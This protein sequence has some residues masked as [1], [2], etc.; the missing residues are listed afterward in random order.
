MQRGIVG[1]TGLKPFMNLV[2]SDG[3]C[4]SVDVYYHMN[5]EEENW[6]SKEADKFG[7]V[8]IIMHCESQ[9]KEKG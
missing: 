2:N 5:V 4:M 6:G 8:G 3:K 7:V 1:G 9:A